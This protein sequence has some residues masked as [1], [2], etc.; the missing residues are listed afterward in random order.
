MLPTCIFD[1]ANLYQRV[2]ENQERRK[3][4]HSV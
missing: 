2:F 3:K 4:V 1:T